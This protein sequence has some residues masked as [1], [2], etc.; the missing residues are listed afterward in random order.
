[1]AAHLQVQVLSP[2]DG[3]HLNVPASNLVLHV[4]VMHGVN[5]GA[6]GL[7]ILHD[8]AAPHALPDAVHGHHHVA[9]CHADCATL[10]LGQV[11]LLRVDLLPLWCLH[12]AVHISGYHCSDRRE[13]TSIQNSRKLWVA[14]HN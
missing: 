10:K 9:H 7:R 12:A 8:G 13:D 11:G 4:V 14:C 6:H 3:K 5:A 2:L 1:M